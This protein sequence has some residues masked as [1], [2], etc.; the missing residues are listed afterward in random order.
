MNFFA[1][2]IAIGIVSATR[3]AFQMLQLKMKKE[4]TDRRLFFF[5]SDLFSFWVL[6]FFFPGLLLGFSSCLVASVAFWLLWLLW[7]RFRSFFVYPIASLKR[8]GVRLESK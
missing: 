2:G 5:R 1:P 3:T 4:K 6:A 8:P 7:L